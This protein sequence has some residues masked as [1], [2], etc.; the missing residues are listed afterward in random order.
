[1]NTSFVSDP[2]G[3]SVL[4][5]KYNGVT[6]ATVNTGLLNSPTIVGN[7]GATVNITSLPGVILGAVS[8]K[9]NLVITLP[10]GVP[11]SGVFQLLFTGGP[12]PGLADDIA[13]QSVSSLSCVNADA[14]ND[15]IINSLDLDSDGDGCPDAIEGGAAFITSNLVSSTMSGGNS[16][17]GFN[18]TSPVPVTQNLGNTVGSTTATMGVPTIAGMG[19]TIGISQNGAVNG[20]IDTDGDG[21]LDLDDLDDDNDG[22][23][24]TVEE[25]DCEKIING[26]GANGFTGWT[27]TG[28]VFYNL[29]PQF[30][31]NYGDSAPTGVLSQTI[32]TIPNQGLQLKFNAVGWG[33]NTAGNV[34]VR[35]DVLAGSTVIAT[36]TVTKTF[37]IPWTIETL[38][39]TPTSTS[40][41]IRFTDV[42]TVATQF[43]FIING[44]SVP[45]ACDLDGDGIVNSLDLDSDGD[46]CADALEG[47]AAF[48]TSNLVSSTMAG[49]ST[50][51]TKNLPT[52][53]GS[54]TATMGVPTIAGTGQAIG[55]SQTSA[56]NG[57]IDTDGDGVP[58]L[59][60]LDDDNDGILDTVEDPACQKII[61]GTGGLNT[62]WTKTGNI[63][64]FTGFFGFNRAGSTPN[65]VLS[66]TVTTVPNQNLQLTFTAEVF[67][68]TAGTV[69]MRLDIVQGGSVIATKTVTKNLGNP[70]TTET[71]NFTP[72]PGAFTVRFTD[73]SLS[74][75]DIDFNLR[76]ISLLAAC[77]LDTDN[78][79]IVNSLDLDAD[80]DGCADALEGGAAFTT[81][82]LVSSTMAG[83]STNVTKNL[84]TPVGSTT[85]TMGVPTIAGTGQTTGTSQNSSAKDP[86]CCLVTGIA[87]TLSATSKANACPA[88][89]VDLSTI[90]VS[91]APASTSLTW[92][93][94]AT[95]TAANRITSVSAVAAGTYFAALYDASTDCYS[96]SATTPVTAVTA[97]CCSAT[98]APALS[99]TTKANTCPATTVDL[100]TITATNQPA[101]STLTWHTSSPATASNRITNITSVTA[102]TYFAAFFDAT[103]NCFS[104]TAV[105]QVTATTTVCCSATLAPALSASSKANACPATTVDLS[106]ITA[107]N[108]PASTT[109]TWHTGTPAT[110]SNRITNISSVTAG[111]Y[112]A[113]FFDATANC[114][115]G[116]A[117]TQV[118]ATTTVCCSATLA[119][120]LS[121]TTKA[122][123]CPATTV[124]LS[125]ITATNQPASSTLTWH[126]G[127]PATASNRITN[128]TSVTAGTYFAAFFD[129]TANCF[130]GTAVTQVTATTT[131]CCSATLAPALSAT[132]KANA[133][134]ATT[135]DLS[136]ITATNQPASTTLTW[137][138]GTP[139][140]AS[141]RITNITSVT[142]GTYFAAFFDA[143]ANCFSGTAVTQVTATTVACC[144]NPSVGGSLT[145]VGTL[146]LCSVSNQGVLTLSGQ[147]GTVVKWQTSTN[148]G[149]SWTDI[150]NTAGLTQISFSNAQNN[151]QF[152]AVVNAGGS[153]ADA[154]SAPFVTLTSASACS[155]DCDVKPGTINKN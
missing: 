74:T 8:A 40:T 1:Q 152:R 32:S 126:T 27:K 49:G 114:F 125:T 128:I 2:A 42:S 82:N 59:D 47:G 123:T 143:T 133:C 91:N 78:D 117:V 118:T 14:D 45:G 115:S 22:I 72:G 58:D 13:I 37:G 85:A 38:N 21:V 61:N 31:F 153:C 57:C 9:S 94:S 3:Q 119:P 81:S 12:S 20:C 41:T 65:G 136:T 140:T 147:T 97:A 99:A 145:L 98:L 18:G 146:P 16:G 87:P 154:N 116:T 109:L 138:T 52:P 96:G 77:G 5:V 88:T 60:D 36:K 30:S 80:G 7:N 15:G 48:T 141:N 67:G 83:G 134:P 35:V 50:N 131:V 150:G 68:G 4:E 93:T 56:V 135:I 113:A 92:H 105:T 120:A 86:A 107:T 132:S 101:S 111:T 79:G 84:P 26:S 100:S 11:P 129:A 124:D 89:T 121:A 95:A 151:Q 44:V 53:V 73:V 69:G 102:G 149:T 75:F 51:V 139:A 127:S 55:V 130:S 29:L 90:T 155:V 142:A 24:D 112:F 63:E 62:G 25:G 110:A 6:Y 10:T 106:T 43:D 39:F 122:N 137:H 76:N 34:S 17:A 70:N 28:N 19:Q 148:G 54:T 104:G 46:G 33:G 23:L 64:E 108:Q 144:P 66:Q 103:A 71:L